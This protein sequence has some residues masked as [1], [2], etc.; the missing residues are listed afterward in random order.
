MKLLVVS[1]KIFP[2]VALAAEPVLERPTL[3][4]LGIYWIVPGGEESGNAV[5]MEYRK[6]GDARWKLVPPLFRVERGKHLAEKYGSKLDVP[7]ESTLFAGSVVNFDP[8]AAYELKLTL[9]GKL[10]AESRAI[11]AGQVLADSMTVLRG[12]VQIWA[13]TKRGRRCRI[14]GRAVEWA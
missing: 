12:R 9:T 4:C 11:D 14:T 5:A 6:A 8:D 7:A 2:M 13:R 1:V 10:A 3:R